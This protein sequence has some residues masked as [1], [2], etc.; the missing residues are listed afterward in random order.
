MHDCAVVLSQ[1]RIQNRII[2]ES[3]IGFHFTKSFASFS[4]QVSCIRLN[5]I[6]Q[7]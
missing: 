4:D 2:P 3:K 7:L 6:E 1:I 5:I